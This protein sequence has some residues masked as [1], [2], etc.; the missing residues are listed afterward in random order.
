MTREGLRHVKELVFRNAY[1]KK[2]IVKGNRDIDESVEFCERRARA[3][4]TSQ[5]IIYY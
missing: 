5:K 1:I 4:E 2:L 3:I